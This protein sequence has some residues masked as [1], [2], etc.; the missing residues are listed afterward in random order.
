M[1]CENNLEEFD[2]S[3]AIRN[4]HETFHFFCSIAERMRETNLSS[5]QCCWF[6]AKIIDTWLRDDKICNQAQVLHKCKPPILLIVII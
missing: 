6:S 2:K 3:K 5:R 1:L 4:P